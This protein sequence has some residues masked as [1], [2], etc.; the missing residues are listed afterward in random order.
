[1]QDLAIHKWWIRH[2]MSIDE[3]VKLFLRFYYIYNQFKKQLPVNSLY[4][5]VKRTFKKPKMTTY[6]PE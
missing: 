5:F 2:Y 1:M 3:L 4:M 6:D